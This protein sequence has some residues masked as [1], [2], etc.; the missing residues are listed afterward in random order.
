MK[1]VALI[2]VLTSLSLGGT[3]V[4]AQSTADE[5]A[6][7]IDAVTKGQPLRDAHELVEAREQFRICARAECPAR[8]RTDCAAWLSEIDK[9]M[10]TVVLSAKDQAGRDVADVKVSVDGKPLVDRLDGRAVEV[11]P[12]MRSFRFERR[13]GSVTTQ[14]ALVKEGEKARSVSVELS[15]AS[16]G[17]GSGESSGAPTPGSTA[18]ALGLILGG[19]GVVTLAVGFGVAF[20][21]KSKDDAS[22]TES[23]A[24]QYN[25]SGSAVGEGNAATV[26]L[27]V[28]AAVAVTGVVLWLTAPRAKTDGAS[29]SSAWPGRG[30]RVA[31]DGRALILRGTFW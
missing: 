18:R 17:A 1:R 30:L 28:G 27:G 19:V 13:D 29:A 3:S 21:A 23:G 26:V 9:T 14:E 12:G 2:V 16:R 6:V 20:D 5:K 25:D 4:R 31:T 22:K 11:D 10:P 15:G 24:A 7:C 8:L